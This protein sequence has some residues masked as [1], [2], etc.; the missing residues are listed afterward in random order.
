MKPEEVAEQIRELETAR[1]KIQ[2]LRLFTTLALLAISISGVGAIIN[3]IYTLA[4]AGPKHDEFISRTGANLQRDLLPL[5]VQIATHSMQQL[6]PAAQAE[7]QKC[8]ARAP[9][10]A[11]VTFRELN[12]MGAELPAR[13]DQILDQTVS[14]T[15][16]QRETKLRHMYPGL[17]DKQ[18]DALLN[19]LSLE[20][21]EQLGKSGERFF[22]P[23]LNSIQGILADLDKIQRTES[24]DSGDNVDCWQVAFMFMDVFVHEFKGISSCEKVILKTPDTGPLAQQNKLASK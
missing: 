23:H 18:V 20:A 9:E 6:K 10:V 12:Q 7:L 21:E 13:M 8:N 24:V 3:S 17:Y 16:H 5:G 14:A 15:L 22:N 19:N 11:D 1:R 2:R 4:L